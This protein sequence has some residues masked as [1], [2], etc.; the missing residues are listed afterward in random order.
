M[1]S[2]QNKEASDCVLFLFVNEAYSIFLNTFRFLVFIFYAIWLIFA[3]KF[4]D[5]HN[6]SMVYLYNVNAVSLAYALYGIQLSLLPICYQPSNVHCFIQGFINLWNLY[7]PGYSLCALVCH[8]LA[9]LH[10][11][12]LNT[13]FNLK[14]VIGSLVFLWGSTT[15]LTLFNFFV[16]N[17]QGIFTPNVQQ[18]IID[19]P[20]KIKLVFFL[21]NITLG[22]LL[23]NVV[24]LIVYAMTIRKIRYLNS[25]QNGKRI[26][27]P[28]I[29]IQLVIYIFA[30]EIGIIASCIQLYLT[31]Y[32]NVPVMVINWTRVLKWL[33]H[34]CPLGLLFLHPILL[35]KYKNWLAFIKC[36]T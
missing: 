9:S 13:K 1:N 36:R 15:F 6:K 33:Q 11:K 32:G 17:V 18:C 34:I 27:P 31:T 19:V 2:T 4:K 3:I 23:P 28:R 24:I 29:T 25:L 26:Q 16:L 22:A 5:F 14:I 35:K 30:Y 21:Y 12:N 8:R 7:L 10:L 20:T